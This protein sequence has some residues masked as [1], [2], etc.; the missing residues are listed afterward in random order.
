[1]VHACQLAAAIGALARPTVAVRAEES[2]NVTDESVLTPAASSHVRSS[3]PGAATAASYAGA[4]AGA[5]S[6]TGV[7]VTTSP[8]GATARAGVTVSNEAVTRA[9]A[10]ADTATIRADRLAMVRFFPLRRGHPS[11]PTH[12]HALSTP[13]SSAAAS[14]QR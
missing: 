10:A 2:V 9:H 13:P 8:A 7:D 6:A 12:A 14:S 11:Q 3:G 4:S 1:M 5:P